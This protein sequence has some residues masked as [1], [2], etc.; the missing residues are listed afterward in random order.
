MDYLKQYG[1]DVIHCDICN[2]TGH[3][4]ER[5]GPGIEITVRECD[6]MNRRRSIRALRKS[7]LEELIEIYTFKKYQTP[8]AVTRGIKNGALKFCKADPAWF[9]ISGKPGSGKTHICTAICRKF[10]QDG[11]RVHYMRWMDEVNRFKTMKAMNPPPY[12]YLAEMD[13]IKTVPVL[14]VDDFLKGK[15]SAADMNLAFEILN[16]RYNQP[17]KRTIISSERSIN[18]VIDLDQATGSR[19]RQRAKGYTFTA[20]PRNWRLEE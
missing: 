19:I 3:I 20:P 17:S 14:Y 10:I 8:D 18:D 15:T 16:T 9:F 13:F 6:C 12:E 2:D 11:E 5:T 4:V 7:G 1:L